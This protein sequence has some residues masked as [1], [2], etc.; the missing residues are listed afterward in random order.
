MNDTRSSDFKN[1]TRFVCPRSIVYNSV[2]RWVI[3]KTWPAT[4]RYSG[5]FGRCSSND[6]PLACCTVGQVPF[7]F[8]LQLHTQRP[9]PYFWSTTIFAT[10][11]RY[12]PISSFHYLHH[13]PGPRY[14]AL[15]MSAARSPKTSQQLN[16]TTQRNNTEDNTFKR[17]SSVTINCLQR[18]IRLNAKFNI[19]QILQWWSY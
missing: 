15:K 19:H 12:W 11:L 1:T 4:Y 5:V 14:D 8:S 7:L 2:Y 6:I 9:I 10:L 16:A 18:E 3:K 17:K 13:P